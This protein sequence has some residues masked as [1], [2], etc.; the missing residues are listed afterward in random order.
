MLGSRCSRQEERGSSGVAPTPS[1]SS[2]STMSHGSSSLPGSARGTP[3]VP[4]QH[5]RLASSSSNSAWYSSGRLRDPG[6]LRS[7][8]VEGGMDESS[9]ASPGTQKASEADGWCEENR[10]ADLRAST[11]YATTSTPWTSTN[12]ELSMSGYPV[13]RSL[14]P[15][16][17]CLPTPDILPDGARPKPPTLFY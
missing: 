14:P 12:R 5:L 17:R 13:H 7:F 11:A 2:P 15:A 6:S 3:A 1:T 4:A 9:E 16:R 10:S 8:A